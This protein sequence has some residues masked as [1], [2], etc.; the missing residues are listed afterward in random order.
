MIA[1]RNKKTHL[2]QSSDPLHLENGGRLEALQIQY[3]TFG[4]L[5]SEKSN[6]VWVFHALTANS[7]MSEW[8]EYLFTEN[9]FINPNKHFILCANMLGSCY[10]STAPD[11]YDF[12]QLVIGDLVSA[13]KKLFEHLGL[14]KIEIG[15]GGSMGGQQLLEWAVQDPSVFNTI[16]PI[17]TN[18]VHSPWGIAFNETQ[19]MALEH[20]DK[21]KGIEIAR[22]MAMLSYRNYHTYSQTQKDDDF[23]HDHFSASSYQRYQG[24]KLRKRFS[25]YSYYYLSKAMDSHN[26][27]R[28]YQSITKALARIT[29]KTLII[30]IESDL[31]FPVSEQQY[32]TQKI[33]NAI[34]NII[35][36]DYG[37]DGFLMETKKIDDILKEELAC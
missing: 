5:N 22:A 12:P 11:S 37:H 34:L 15:M 10:G 25:H 36:S 4:S 30:G 9:S 31:L 20:P 3:T 17:A 14:S 8:W 24:I 33:P 23:R 32:I 13:Y 19:R 29:A 35:T 28:K 2:Y 18:A 21:S 16:V 27:G 7:D 26:V 6:V 1:H